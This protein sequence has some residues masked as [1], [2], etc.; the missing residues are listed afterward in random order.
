M[1]RKEVK[2][3]NIEAVKCDV[4]EQETTVVIERGSNLVK[5]FSS[6]NTMITK[7]KRAISRDKSGNWKCYEGSRNRDG[8]LT[9][10]FFECPKKCVTFRGGSIQKRDHEPNPNAFGRGKQNA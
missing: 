8:Y 2:L 3:E 7:I 6:D 5:V 10:Y 4:R 9:G 1:E